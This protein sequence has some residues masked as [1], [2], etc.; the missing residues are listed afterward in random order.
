[1]KFV[2]RPIFV[3]IPIAAVGIVVFACRDLPT[4]V[5]RS[6]YLFALEKLH[7]GTARN[8]KALFTLLTSRY[9]QKKG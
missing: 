1:M 6:D 9:S 2:F 8:D 7:P 4:N 5:N 3:E